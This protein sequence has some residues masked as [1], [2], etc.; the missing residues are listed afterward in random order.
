MTQQQAEWHICVYVC[1]I[2]P[3]HT[4]HTHT[5]NKKKD[6]ANTHTHRTIITH[7]YI[8]LN[9]YKNPTTTTTPSPPHHTF[10]AADFSRFAS[11]K[12]QFLQN[13]SILYYAKTTRKDIF[14]HW[15]CQWT[16]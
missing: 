11:Q 5:Q 14:H 9:K 13:L 4:T 2:P 1:F 16:W 6:T 12:S 3:T 7:T 8:F 15:R 10:Y